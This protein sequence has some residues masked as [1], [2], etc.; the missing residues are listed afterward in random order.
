MVN[1]NELSQASSSKDS[2]KLGDRTTITSTTPFTTVIGRKIDILI[3]D[4]ENNELSLCEFKARQ[5]L[6]SLLQQQGKSIRTNKCILMDLLS[7][8]LADNDDLGKVMGLHVAG[9][10]SNNGLYDKERNAQ[11]TLNFI[12]QLF[13][14]IKTYWLFICVGTCI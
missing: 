1:K 4:D 14:L 9:K 2:A 13:Y 12:L 5:Q 7:K 11:T 8:G 10:F 6:S 3:K